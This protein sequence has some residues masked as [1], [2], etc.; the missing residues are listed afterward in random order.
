MIKFQVSETDGIGRRD[1]YVTVNAGS[2]EIARAKTD[3]TAEEAVS[4]LKALALFP[5]L[6]F[7]FSGSKEL[8]RVKATIGSAVGNYIRGKIQVGD[9]SG[10]WEAH[11]I[12]SSRF[13]IQVPQRGYADDLPEHGWEIG[14]PGFVLNLDPVHR[15]RVAV[16]IEEMIYKAAAKDLDSPGVSRQISNSFSL[17]DPI[18][19]GVPIITRAT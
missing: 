14:F 17:E 3:L 5:D 11:R 6:E 7:T 9:I 18:W 1:A 16:I 4:S 13:D 19:S 8:I 2:K 15:L 10:F 12:R